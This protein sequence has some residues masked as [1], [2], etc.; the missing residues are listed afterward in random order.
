MPRVSP[1][2]S[3][4]SGF[5]RG[6]WSTSTREL[7]PVCEADC[8][9]PPHAMV[10]RGPSGPH[11]G[12]KRL[13]SFP[14]WNSAQELAV[15]VVEKATAARFFDLSF[16]KATD[17]DLHSPYTRAHMGP[18]RASSWKS[19]VRRWKLLSGSCGRGMRR[20]SL[21]RPEMPYVHFS[22][23]IWMCASFEYPFGVCCQGKPNRNTQ[24]NQAQESTVST[25]VRIFLLDDVGREFER[26]PACSIGLLLSSRKCSS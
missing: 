26:R 21:L 10:Q 12:G 9:G 15:G 6:L 24:T 13:E 14:K 1:V 18:W 5:C 16:L 4:R 22:W 8:G 7:P 3:T 17:E 25:T 19:E 2:R 20:C 23:R 11:L